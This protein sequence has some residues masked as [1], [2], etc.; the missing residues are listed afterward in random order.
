ML[1]LLF[2]LYIYNYFF[3]IKNHQEY[4]HI[5][6][7]MHVPSLCAVIKILLTNLK[8]FILISALFWLVNF[9]YACI[10]LKMGKW[11]KN[12]FMVCVI[13]WCIYGN[14]SFCRKLSFKCSG[15]RY[16]T[17][18]IPFCICY[19]IDYYDFVSICEYKKNVGN[20]STN[21]VIDYTPTK[22]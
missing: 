7:K 21:I 9:E 18:N 3:H 13:I 2:F 16:L 19:V 17:S 5:Q 1:C 6:P 12:Y 20:N 14:L 22:E 10:L 4:Y 8:H 11:F 15:I